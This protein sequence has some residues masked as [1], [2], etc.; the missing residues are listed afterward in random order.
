MPDNHWNRNRFLSPSIPVIDVQIGAADPGF[1]DANQ[2]VIDA[3][4]R[5]RDIL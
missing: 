3:D 5:K 4:G 1:V 2:A